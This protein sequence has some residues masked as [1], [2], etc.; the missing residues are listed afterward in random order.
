[1]KKIFILGYILFSFLLYG[2]NDTRL[3]R[4]NNLV[5]KSD[6]YNI[7]TTSSKLQMYHKILKKEESKEYYSFILIENQNY[8]CVLHIA[9][10]IFSLSL[11]DKKTNEKLVFFNGGDKEYRM[12]FMTGS[13][14]GY[15]KEKNKKYKYSFTV[16]LQERGQYYEYCL[17]NNKE[18][19]SKINF[20]GYE[21]W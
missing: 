19:Y 16:S 15:I 20:Y 4:L 17:K 1:M 13:Y 2:C 14:N 21:N 3:V 18:F 5:W 6:V 11:Y 8:N 10:N 7:E 9:N 12:P